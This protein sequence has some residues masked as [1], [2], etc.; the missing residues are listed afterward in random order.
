YLRHRGPDGQATWLH[1]QGCVGLGHTR[2]SIIDLEGGKQRMESAD[3]RH[4]IVFN[5]EIYNYQSIRRQLE[6]LG[7]Q[8]RTNS[9][10]EV[11]LEAYKRWGVA[12]LD[13]LRGMY[14]FAIYDRVDHLLFLA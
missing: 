5:G 4:L 14:A 9:D 6:A 13:R 8:F 7:H 12:T 1:P 10:T 11:L 3:S 2:L